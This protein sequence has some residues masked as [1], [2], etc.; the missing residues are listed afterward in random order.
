MDRKFNY[1]DLGPKIVN[2]KSKYRDN[3]QNSKLTYNFVTDPRLKR[4][5]NFGVIYVTSSNYEEETKTM[6]GRDTQK[7]PTDKLKQSFNSKQD[8]RSKKEMLDARKYDV[9]SGFGVCT[10]KV[11]DT[12]RPKPITFEVEVQTD[13][14]PP[15]EQEKLVWPEKTGVDVETQIEDGELFNFDEEVMPL[16]HIIVSKTI[17]DSRREVLEEEERAEIQQQQKNYEKLMKEDAERVA[18]IEKNEKEKFEEKK[19]KKAAKKERIEMTKMFQQ[20][21]VSRTLSKN[22][23]SKLM[24]N[25]L[26]TLEKR[27]IFKKPEV[28]EYYMELLPELQT[29][30]E[31]NHKNDYLISNGLREMLQSK[32][33]ANCIQKHKDAIKKEKER[34]EEE[35]RQRILRKKQ[36]EEERQRQKEERRRRRHEKLLN[37]IRQSITEELLINSEF[38]EDIVDNIYDINGYYQKTK[39]VTCVGGP[40]GQIALLLCELNKITP[41]FIT[42]D[43]VTRIMDLYLPKSHSFF[44]IYSQEDL[45]DYKAINEEIAAIEDIVKCE[46]D[47]YEKVVQKLYENNLKQDDTLS[48]VIDLAKNTFG[49]D[50]FEDYYLMIF[51]YLLKKFKDASD[52]DVVKFVARD[53]ALDEVPLSAI[54]LMNAEVVPLSNPNEQSIPMKKGIP[55][56]KPA[57]VTFDPFFCEKTLLMPTIS[58]KLRIISINQNFDRV[59]RDNMLECINK[60]YKLDPDKETY[61]TTINKDYEKFVKGLLLKLAEVYKKEIVE[62]TVEQPKEGGEEEGNA[63]GEGEANN[64]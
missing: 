39:N 58:D 49:F 2:S 55:S 23:L 32:H 21:L 47:Q 42:D 29:L 26:N 3:E 14:L 57:K 15:K 13:A 17:E 38:A 33:K 10:E 45:E 36:E 53:H 37:E 31:T 41:D 43:K 35:E 63:E 56:K 11:I 5:H 44:F 28:N 48:Y 40:I 22:Y 46:D 8:E 7:R 19:K 6:G 1:Y 9:N 54:C 30:A 59:F 60:L 64:A 50:K 51:N 12:V 27:G 61:V 24:G 62:M 16:V 18:N 34:R 25:S 4:G 20:K 52:G